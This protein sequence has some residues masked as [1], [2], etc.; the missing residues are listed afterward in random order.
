MGYYDENEFPVT[1][2]TLLE[3]YID[4]KEINSDKK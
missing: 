4:N 3:R 1:L 2:S